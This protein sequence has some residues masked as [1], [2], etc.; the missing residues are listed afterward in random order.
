MIFFCAALLYPEYQ[1]RHRG[2]WD[3]SRRKGSPIMVS[4]WSGEPAASYQTWCFLP[5]YSFLF[6]LSLRTESTAS[7]QGLRRPMLVTYLTTTSMHTSVYLCIPHLYS[8][9]T[10][11]CHDCLSFFMY[12]ECWW[13][14]DV[15]LRA[16]SNG[17][18]AEKCQE[19]PFSSQAPQTAS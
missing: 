18:R 9:C 12:R 14:W 7:L 6:Q 3:V 5:S 13:A 11:N 2:P 17:R 1:R 8:P 4:V 10:S 15:S 19:W 16:S